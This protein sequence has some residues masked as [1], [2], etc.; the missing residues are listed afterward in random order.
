MNRKG[1]NLFQEGRE[2]GREVKRGVREISGENKN[3]VFVI[4]V[5][6]FCVLFVV[7]K[8]VFVW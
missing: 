8:V 3:V 7:G 1:G 2:V 5:L 4:F 6:K